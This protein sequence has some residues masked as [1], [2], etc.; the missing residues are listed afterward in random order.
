MEN[1]AIEQLR[2]AR[3]AAKGL[4][5]FGAMLLLHALVMADTPGVAALRARISELGM[6]PMLM[7]LA[8]Q[9]LQPQRPDRRRRRPGLL[10]VC[11]RF[12]R[13]SGA[14]ARYAL[15]GNGRHRTRRRYG[16][17]VV[18]SGVRARRRTRAFVTEHRGIDLQL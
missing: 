12:V 1:A 17:A 13:G 8:R 16:S 7:S 14:L 2:Q 15:V 5:G 6:G 11:P 18:R 3:E 9:V 10:I 4:A